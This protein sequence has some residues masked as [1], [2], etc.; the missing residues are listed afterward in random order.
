MAKG[1]EATTTIKAGKAGTFAPGDLVTGLN[2]EQMAQLWEAGALK[3][4]EVADSSSGGSD[5][6]PPPVTVETSGG[7]GPSPATEGADTPPA[8]ETGSEGS[9]QGGDTEEGSGA[10]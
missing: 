7:T 8:E 10:D 4:A 5:A 1:W 2:K 6:P 3:E 9:G